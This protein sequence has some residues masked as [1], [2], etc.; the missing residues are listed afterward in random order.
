V[1]H[2]EEVCF[3]GMLEALSNLQQFFK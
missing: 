1:L 3:K 2:P